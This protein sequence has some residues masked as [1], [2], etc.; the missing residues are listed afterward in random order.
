MMQFDYFFVK[1]L[2]SDQYFFIEIEVVNK[3]VFFVGIIDIIPVSILMK[4][5]NEND[6]VV[7]I[8]K[9]LEPN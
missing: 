4:K 5:F 8:F 7:S 2:E 1:S 9:K 3:I 6:Q